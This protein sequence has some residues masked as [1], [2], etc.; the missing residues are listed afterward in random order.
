MHGPYYSSSLP[1]SPS[2]SPMSTSA[3]PLPLTLGLVST[4]WHDWRTKPE[5]PPTPPLS[6]IPQRRVLVN[7]QHLPQPSLPPISHLDRSFARHTPPVTPPTE[8]LVTKYDTY[9]YRLPSAIPPMPSRSLD[10][11]P[12]SS[13]SD[14]HED[15]F[16]ST[17]YQLDWFGSDSHRS[18]RFI[19]E[20]T[21]EMI[22]YLWFST[23]SSS[24]S[25]S[26]SKRNR[27]AS[28]YHP[29]FSPHSNSATAKLQFSV[30]PAFTRFMQKVLETTQVS[31]SVIVLSLHYIYRLKGRNPYTSGQ[32]GSEYRVAIAALMLANKFVDD[33]TYTNKTW[34]E[35]SGIELSQVNRMEREFL[36]GI[37]FDLYVDKNTYDGWL[38]VLTGLV[39]HKEQ[40][41]KMWKRTRCPV[42]SSHLHRPHC[43]R[44][45]HLTPSRASSHRARSS[46]PR[47]ASICAVSHSAP[48]P[49]HPSYYTPAPPPPPQPVQP[50]P[51]LVAYPSPVRPE[52]P[53]GCKRTASDAFS[54]TS[55]SFPAVDQPPAQ[56][57]RR[58]QGLSLDI[59][60]PTAHAYSRESS[61]SPLE[62][63]QSFS[64]LN[65][66]TS[67]VDT[68]PAQSWP[69]RHDEYPRTLV[70]AYRMDDQR[71]PVAPQNLYFYSLAGSPM[72]SEEERRSRKA[73]LRY[74]QAPPPTAAFYQY[75]PSMPMVVQSASTSPYE[76]H[77]H[78]PAPQ[79]VLP[80]FSEVSQS[81]QTT[82][83]LQVPETT[84]LPPILVDHP[85]Q[86]GS[87]IPSAPFANAGP[88][89]V[90]FYSTMTPDLAPHYYRARGR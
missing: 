78:V 11:S 28:S 82:A 44:N 67:P 50:V 9:S 84:Q 52:L 30:S 27:V 43:H 79:P 10:A 87:S 38:R 19:A 54:P 14:V 21:C 13:Q 65:L 47:R 56:V 62:S 34:S 5:A 57:P 24:S 49:S 89:G 23:I 8:H 7:S 37:D 41:S 55:A 60:Q 59:P 51:Q 48:F 70:S 88:S 2:P 33:N 66:G 53:A 85:R 29:S 35:V 64:K 58:M 18:A 63:L 73:R 83:R 17:T 16:L 6:S 1:P 90:Q 39:S 20:K 12:S 32:A 31:Q 69:A 25:E 22:C 81:W 72:E 71:P 4:T 61:A 86:Q 80:P 74:H 40:D 3:L 75:P 45:A 77:S 26:P 42:R 68:V 15:P 46:S 76:V 36:L